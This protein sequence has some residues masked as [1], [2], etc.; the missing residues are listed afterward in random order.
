MVKRIR[1]LAEITE[2]SL[3]IKKLMID[4]YY[5]ASDFEIETNLFEQLD[6][7]KRG[8]IGGEE[9]KNFL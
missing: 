6:D 3:F 8:V 2:L 9:L 4:F 1:N 5:D 7:R